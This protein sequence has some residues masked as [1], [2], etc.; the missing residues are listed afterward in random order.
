MRILVSKKYTTPQIFSEHICPICRKVFLNNQGLRVH[1]IRKHGFT[2]PNREPLR[3]SNWVVEQIKMKKKEML[4]TIFKCPYCGFIR[5]EKRKWK[6]SSRCPNCRALL[7]K[8]T[9]INNKRFG[10]V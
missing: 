2:P 3:Y 8:T 5:E 1:Y 7:L 9:I 6:G 4:K 10:K